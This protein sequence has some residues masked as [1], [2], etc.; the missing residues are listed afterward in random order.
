LIPVLIRVAKYFGHRVREI[1]VHF[2]RFF[3]STELQRIVIF[4]SYDKQMGSSLLRAWEVGNE[5]KKRKWR[6]TVVPSQLE[7]VQRQRILKYENPDFV[8]LQKHVHP[9]NNP[10]FYKSYRC[11][12]DLD[13]A[14]FLNSE[15][16]KILIECV[17]GSELV[18]AG[19]QYIR[20]WCH[21]Y[22]ENVEVIWTGTP[23]QQNKFKFHPARRRNIIAWASSAPLKNPFEM[24]F[25]EDVLKKVAQTHNI[26]FWL[27]GISPKQSPIK[28]FSKLDEYN[29]IT[30]SFSYM[31]YKDY[32]LTLEEVA[33]GLQPLM[34]ET[35][36]YA[37]GKSFGKVLAYL[38]SGV[39]V[40]AS[41]QA[42]HGEFFKSGDNGYL[43]TDADEWAVVIGNLLDNPELRSVVANKAYNDYMKK[44]S[45]KAVVRKVDAILRRNL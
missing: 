2:Q 8:I 34:V 24:R 43:V 23:L 39:V 42:D 40:V 4:P 33:I 21:K 41:D 13:D 17:K 18:F 20:E 26:E 9:L 37:K 1:L 45:T 22:N 3:Q 7:L 36:P 14:D 29:I 30:K 10:H 38:A 28:F 27:Y 6:V 44:L 5:L 25:I 35:N 16:I 19:S 11:I 32:L 12:F 31:S 15:K